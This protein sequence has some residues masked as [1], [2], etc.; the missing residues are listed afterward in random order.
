MLVAAADS[1]SNSFMPE[2][3]DLLPALEP[4][5]RTSTNPWLAPDFRDAIACTERKKIV[6][7]G[8]WTCAC[9]SF[10]SFDLLRVGYEVYV[11]TDA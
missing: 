6:L 5:D 1:F 7:A 3:T 10:P 9:V 8:L 11:P 2:V 4:I